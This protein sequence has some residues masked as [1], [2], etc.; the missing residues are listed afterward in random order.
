MS[1]NSII[2][3]RHAESIHN[4][5]GKLEYNSRLSEHGKS[6]CQDLTM[7]ADLVVCSTLRRARETLDYSNIK[8][9]DVIFTDLCREVLSGNIVNHYPDEI[10]SIETEDQVLHRIKLFKRL[11]NKLQET[12]KTI[13]VISHG[14]FLLRLTGRFF[15]NCQYIKYDLH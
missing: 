3:I 10:V 13:C 6:K 14:T 8:Y 12:N 2:L 15:N 11:L 9:K 7:Q 4:A 1:K 5:T